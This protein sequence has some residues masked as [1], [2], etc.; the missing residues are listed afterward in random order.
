MAWELTPSLELDESESSIGLS[1]T[2][3]SEVRWRLFC[4]R[5]GNTTP[6]PRAWG[7]AIFLLS[8]VT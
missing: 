3:G 1:V 7:G 8:F 2:D 5:C 4:R 6:K